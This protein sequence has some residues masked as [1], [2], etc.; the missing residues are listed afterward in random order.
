MSVSLYALLPL[1]LNGRGV[2]YTCGS[3]ANGMADRDFSVTIVTPRS[4]WLLPSVEVI[5]VLPNWARYLPYRWVREKNARGIE[6]VFLSCIDRLQSQRSAAYL[7][8]NATFETLQ[9]LKRRDVTI[10]REQFNCHTG[11]AKKILDRAY[12]R[13]GVTPRHGITTESVDRE[14]RIAE[15]VDH[16]FCPSPLVEA[17]L[18]ENGVPAQKVL[19]ASYGWDPA[20]L[21]GNHT[22]LPSNDGLTAV[23]VGAICV[24]KGA[25]LLLDYWARSEVKG[26]LVL[27]G[28]MEPIIKEKCANL[29]ARDD[30]TVLDYFRDV[31]SLYRSADI[32]VFPS[33]EEGGPQVTYEACGCGLPVL[34]TPMGAGRIVRHEREGIVLDPYDASGWIAALRALAEDVKLRRNMSSAASVRAQHFMWA[35]VARQRQQQVME[36]IGVDR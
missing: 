19:K 1:P 36:C 26:R 17:S 27:A 24:R 25:H 6:Q 28:E 9:E 35:T 12:E 23:F 21:A 32:F 33:L 22:L 11:T 4:R 14:I 5:E 16:I 18:L 34:T 2:G 3:L 7:W 15:A 8:P 20:R 10:F 31:G 29:L 13:L 30:V